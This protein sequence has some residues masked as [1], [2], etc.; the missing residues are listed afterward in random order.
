MLRSQG[1]DHC[2][3]AGRSHSASGVNRIRMTPQ[4][5]SRRL[6]SRLLSESHFRSQMLNQTVHADDWWVPSSVWAAAAG[7]RH[8]L[9]GGTAAIEITLDGSLHYVA[10]AVRDG[11][12]VARVTLHAFHTFREVG[13]WVRAARPTSV[14][15]PGI[16]KDRLFRVDRTVSAADVASA[17]PVFMAALTGGRI[18]HPSDERLTEQLLMAKAHVTKEGRQDTHASDGQPLSAVRAL[19]WAVA[20]ES[21][22]TQSRPKLRIAQ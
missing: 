5:N 11:D 6:R 18:V 22:T 13:D 21:E 16:Y 9:P 10:H 17:M 7:A 3:V 8:A 20:N 19:L 2:G 1:L 14:L 4:S 12:G 15:A